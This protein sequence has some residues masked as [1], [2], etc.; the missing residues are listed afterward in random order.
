MFGHYIDPRIARQL[1]SS[2]SIDDII[3]HGER[4]DLTMLFV[5]IRGFTAM[6]EAMRAEDGLTAVQEYLAEMSRLIFK[7]DGTIDK[8]AGDEMLAIWNARIDQ[9]EHAR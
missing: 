9:P 4:R 6:P 2:K 5:D 8:V 1:A 3:S 7:W